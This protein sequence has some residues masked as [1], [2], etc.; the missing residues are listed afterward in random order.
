MIKHSVSKLRILNL[1]QFFINICHFV[2]FRYIEKAIGGHVFKNLK[3]K[4]IYW[5]SMI[6]NKTIEKTLDDLK[7]N[8]QYGETFFI[9]GSIS[10]LNRLVQMVCVGVCVGVCSEDFKDRIKFIFY[11]RLIIDQ[12]YVDNENGISFPR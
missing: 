9:L 2:L 10:M 3:H 5:S 7:Y 1:V 8:Y 11:N 6:N 4:E 12:C